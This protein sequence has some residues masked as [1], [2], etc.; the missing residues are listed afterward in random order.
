MS[1]VPMSAMQSF[2]FPCEKKHQHDQKHFL[3]NQQ[4]GRHRNARPKA[5]PFGGGSPHPCLF[6]IEFTICHAS[7][8]HLIAQCEA[9]C[10]E[11]QGIVPW[12][13]AQ[14]NSQVPCLLTQNLRCT[15]I[16][17]LY[18]LTE[19][20]MGTLKHRSPSASRTSTH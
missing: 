9:T 10:R 5:Q 8:W 19:N 4:K 11:H 2:F 3:L 14:A 17:V 6:F 20:A 12:Q 13:L 15:K 7:R 1:S 16:V 18:S